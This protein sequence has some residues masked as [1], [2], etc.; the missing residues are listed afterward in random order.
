M[1]ANIKNLHVSVNLHAIFLHLHLP[2]N[3]V[4]K[5]DIYLHYR[6]VCVFFIIYIY[7]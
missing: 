3:D 1:Q 6:C 7:M 2:T 4:K 5:K